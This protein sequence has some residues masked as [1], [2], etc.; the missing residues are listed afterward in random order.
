MYRTLSAGVSALVLWCVAAGASASLITNGDFETGDFSGWSTYT[1]NSGSHIGSIGSSGVSLFDT[2]NNAVDSF[3]ARFQV[4]QGASGPI[5]GGSPRVGGG[6]LQ[7]FTA[8]GGVLDISLDIA[9]DAFSN[10]GDG[11]LFEL[12]LNGSVLDVFDF[13]STTNG[14]KEFGSLSASTT[15]AAGVHEL[16]IQMSRGY[17][18]ASYTPMQYFDNVVVVQPASVPEPVGIALL[19]LGLVG[20][21]GVRRARR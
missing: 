16:R 7:S 4:G 21:F 15:V 18:N 13:G 19:G 17:G 8:A 5:G 9:I 3:A 20:L 11:G 6:L 14:V 10:N 1:F 2:D 12:I